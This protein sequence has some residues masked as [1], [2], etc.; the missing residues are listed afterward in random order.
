MFDHLLLFDVQPE[1][2]RSFG[3]ETLATFCCRDTRS[4]WL[5]YGFEPACNSSA[6]DGKF[7]PKSKSSHWHTA[8]DP[9]LNVRQSR[10]R[11]R[12]S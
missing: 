10:S 7:R 11:W 2:T 3:T 1:K 5:L 8:Q 6:I 4:Q 9:G 12:Y